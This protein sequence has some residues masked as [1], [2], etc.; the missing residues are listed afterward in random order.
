MHTHGPSCLEGPYKPTS[1]RWPSRPLRSAT[2][3]AISG[4]DLVRGFGPEHTGALQPFR[5]EL[6]ETIR[7]EIAAGTY[8]TAEK[9]DAS[10]DE[11]LRRLVE[12]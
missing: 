9:W 4:C 1:D 7:R 12:E 3:A 2:S 11:V 10:I 6:V 8:E 5:T